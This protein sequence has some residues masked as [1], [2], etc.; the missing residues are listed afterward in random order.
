MKTIDYNPATLAWI[1][2]LPV[3]MTIA[4]LCPQANVNENADFNGRPKTC[5]LGD[6]Q[7]T[8][9][10]SQHVKHGERS[11]K[12]FE[13]LLARVE[14]RLTREC[15]DAVRVEMDSRSILWPNVI[16]S[17]I[18]AFRDEQMGTDPSYAAATDDVCRAIGVSIMQCVTGG[19]GNNKVDTRIT[20]LKGKVDSMTAKLAAA[21]TDKDRSK[22]AARLADAQDELKQ[23]TEEGDEDG[24][25]DNILTLGQGEQEVIVNL[26]KQAVTNF[27]KAPAPKEDG[28]KKDGPPPMVKVVDAVVQKLFTAFKGTTL[29]ARATEG[30][31]TV[32]LH[33]LLFGN[34]STTQFVAESRAT[35]CRS[36]SFSVNKQK[37]GESSFID[38]L[39]A[40]D[41]HA[42]EFG[43]GNKGASHITEFEYAS[44]S[45]FGFESWNVRQAAK[46]LLAECPTFGPKEISIVL[47]E[48]AAHL[49]RTNARGGQGSRESRAPAYSPADTV[50][51]EMTMEQPTTPAAAFFKSIPMSGDIRDQAESALAREIANMDAG[52][53][54]PAARA[55]LPWNR[56]DTAASPISKVALPLSLAELQ[57]WA[58]CT[59]VSKPYQVAQ[60]NGKAK[61]AV[62]TPAV[63][64]AE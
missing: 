25:G 62:S 32:R 53:G 10:S 23:F 3:A 16:A 59:V 24:R 4:V 27:T 60:A 5:P 57:A 39:I 50:V 41:D 26:A 44:Y 17:K 56:L 63:G 52:Y 35:L 1:A 64:D 47:E 14:E 31:R 2:K 22:L 20:D 21:K 61:H 19:S 58:A 43:E 54:P 12:V 38:T 15:G 9:K 28:G 51:V 36:H 8:M 48:T 46:N 33:R 29:T 30:G 55:A 49:V 45:M 11:Q 34:M 42:F 40:S 13:P 6:G 37:E 7:R 18:R